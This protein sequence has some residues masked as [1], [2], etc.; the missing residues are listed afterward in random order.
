MLK[1]VE[2][3]SSDQKFLTVSTVSLSHPES[4]MIWLNAPRNE[5]I[6]YLEF[7]RGKK[8]V[9]ISNRKRQLPA[10]KNDACLIVTHVLL[11]YSGYL[12]GT[13]RLLRRLY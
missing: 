4:Y 6:W 13:C 2:L 5:T 11:G 7:R 12:D 10:G 1:T 8:I 3:Y 9:V